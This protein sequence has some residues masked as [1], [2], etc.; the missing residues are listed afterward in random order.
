MRYKTVIVVRFFWIND[1]TLNRIEF[2]TY[3][4][5]YHWLKDNRKSV[6][7]LS[8]KEEPQLI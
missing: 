5:Y 3:D 8:E 6:E 1:D 2:D 4:G 7:I